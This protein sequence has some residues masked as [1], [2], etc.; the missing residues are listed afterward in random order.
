MM[1]PAQA[2][3]AVI[4]RQGPPPDPD[5]PGPFSL[6]N[7]ER[8]KE[9]LGDAGFQTIDIKSVDVGMS[10]GPL[11]YAVEFFMKMGP[12]ATALL[13]ASEAQKLEVRE[14][15]EKMVRNYATADGVVMPG[16]AWLVA[17]R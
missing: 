2:A 14:A 4:P 1:E 9:L 6:G 11:E 3:F 8:V 16:A 12:A 15:L 13:D 17:A 7:S 10:I 5:A